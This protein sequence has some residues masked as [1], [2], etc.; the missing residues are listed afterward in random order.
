MKLI[1]LLRAIN[2]GKLNKVPMLDLKQ[3][4]TDIGFSNVKT[5]LQSGNIYVESEKIEISDL[6]N[7]LSQRYG[8]NIPVILTDINQII[9]ISEHPNF[10]ENSMVVFTNQLLTDDQIN[11]L[12]TEITEE[13]YALHQCII[14][15][16]TTPFHLTKFNNNWFERR[17]KTYTTVRNRN[18]VLK[19][20]E[21]FK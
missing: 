14:I 8:F 6:E 5:L 16:Y 9:R 11:Q 19:M 20:I 3:Y 2:L 21:S 15:N 18:T 10:K 4:L 7:K 17:L 12:K 1:L 13:F